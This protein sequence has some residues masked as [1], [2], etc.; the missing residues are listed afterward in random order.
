MLV[1]ERMRRLWVRRPHRAQ[2][3]LPYHWG[4]N[5]LVTGDVAE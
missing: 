2:V 5:G 3:G 4:Y 1:T